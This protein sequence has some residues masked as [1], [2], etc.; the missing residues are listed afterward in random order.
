MMGHAFRK[1]AQYWRRKRSDELEVD[2]SCF[3]FSVSLL[4]FFNK[5]LEVERAS[6]TSL[7]KIASCFYNDNQNC[8]QQHDGG[9]WQPV[10]PP[11]SFWSCLL[12]VLSPFG[13]SP[14]G[15]SPFFFPF[16]LNRHDVLN[17]TDRPSCRNS[18]PRAV[19]LSSLETAETIADC[20]TF[21][22][23]KTLVGTEWQGSFGIDGG[24]C[25]MLVGGMQIFD[26][27]VKERI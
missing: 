23:A 19:S 27:S 5:K 24:H 22:P 12:L 15:L 25:G 9:S 20:C 18:R 3:E 16:S 17:S 6:S 21:E 1:G 8:F 2:V 13:L 14:I 11:L 26:A 4:H 7:K 10:A